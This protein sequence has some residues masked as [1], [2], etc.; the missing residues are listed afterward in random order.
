MVE[1]RLSKGALEEAQESKGDEGE[2]QLW[3]GPS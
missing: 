3:G 1:Q 2:E